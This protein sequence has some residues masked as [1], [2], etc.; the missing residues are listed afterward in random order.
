MPTNQQNG[1]QLSLMD[2]LYYIAKYFYP[3]ALKEVA[4]RLAERAERYFQVDICLRL[5]EEDVKDEWS[6]SLFRNRLLRSGLV[7]RDPN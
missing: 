7:R 1:I 2:Q 5:L 6:T 4:L 3:P